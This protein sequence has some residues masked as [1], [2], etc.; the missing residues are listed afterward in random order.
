MLISEDGAHRFQL[1][2]G[3]GHS[4][5]SE[6]RDQFRRG[7][8]RVFRRSSVDH[9]RPKS[10][11]RTRH[12]SC[13]GNEHVAAR[14]GRRARAS[15]RPRQDSDHLCAES[16]PLGANNLC[17]G[18]QS[19]KKEVRLQPRQAKP[20]REAP[21]ASG[22]DSAGRRDHQLLQ[23]AGGRHGDSVSDADQLVPQGVRRN[24]A[25]S[26]H[27]MGR[28][29][30]GGINDVS[31]QRGAGWLASPQPTKSTPAASSVRRPCRSPR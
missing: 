11:S 23:G 18:V 29:E 3:Q 19:M 14:T 30:R 21:E 8:D 27:A 16:N 25:P 2:P 9:R 6:A 5:S 4:E 20:I 10:T 7:A 24:G 17:Q 15:D 26:H 31:H 28:C 1:G 22:H 12:G 13:S